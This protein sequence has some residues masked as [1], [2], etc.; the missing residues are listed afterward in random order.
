MAGKVYLRACIQPAA[1]QHLYPPLAKLG[2]KHIDPDLDAML[3]CI[4]LRW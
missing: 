1:F 3:R 2:V 4:A